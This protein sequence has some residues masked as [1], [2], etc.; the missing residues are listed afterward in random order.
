MRLRRCDMAKITD[1]LREGWHRAED[2]VQA[3]WALVDK[4]GAN[5]DKVAVWLSKRGAANVTL[6][7]IFLFAL[8]AVFQDLGLT[9]IFG[10]IAVGWVYLL[11]NKMIKE[12]MV[13][14]IAK[15]KP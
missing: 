3:Q 14:S 13:T 6:L 11:G 1:T 9:M 12:R 4:Q 10:L 8:A 15:G 5:S 2:E 7:L